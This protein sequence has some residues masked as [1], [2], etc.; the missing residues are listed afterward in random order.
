MCAK[1]H[2]YFSNRN[3]F[4]EVVYDDKGIPIAELDGSVHDVFA[5]I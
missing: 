2:L 1:I 4:D 5:G 3:S